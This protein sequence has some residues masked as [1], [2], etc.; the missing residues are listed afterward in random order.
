MLPLLEVDIIE[1][2]YNTSSQPEG[3]LRLIFQEGG[4]FQ[5][6]CSVTGGLGDQLQ[7]LFNDEVI[8][9]GAMEIG[10][11]L[12]VNIQVLYCIAQN[13]ASSRSVFDRNVNSLYNVLYTY[14]LHMRVVAAILIMVA[15]HLKV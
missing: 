15:Q 5:W 2:P 1:V 7:W 8:P 3:P 4:A 13:S 9:E 14:Y 6:P 11:A 10:E 12:E